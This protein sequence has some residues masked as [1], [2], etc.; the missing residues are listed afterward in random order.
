MVSIFES[1][2]FSKQSENL[3]KIFSSLT[4]T[5][6]IRFIRFRFSVVDN[7]RTGSDF[8]S[9]TKK[10]TSKWSF[11]CFRVSEH[12]P[13]T[14]ILELL[15]VDNLMFTGRR[16]G[17]G[18]NFFKVAKETKLHSAPVSILYETR[19]SFES[20]VIEQSDFSFLIWLIYAK[21]WI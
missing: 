21:F 5:A 12:F 3:D 11:L 15:Y 9:T 10:E 19:I 6:E 1:S 14:G 16:S 2:Y 4:S 13:S 18:S 20:R 8:E 7:P 17:S